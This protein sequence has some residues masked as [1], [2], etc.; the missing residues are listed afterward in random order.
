[1]RAVVR[2]DEKPSD[3]Y[4]LL[5]NSARDA[6]VSPQIPGVRVLLACTKSADLQLTWARRAVALPRRCPEQQPDRH[7]GHG[8]GALCRLSDCGLL[9]RLSPNQTSLGHGGLSPVP[10]ALRPPVRS[11]A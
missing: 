6:S 1:M 10:V 11:V 7:P 9:R 5:Q 2:E 3:L 8:A 4:D